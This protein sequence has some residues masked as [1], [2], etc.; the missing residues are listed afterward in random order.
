MKRQ[1]FIA[2]AWHG[3]SDARQWGYPS[4]HDS[5]TQN[6]TTYEHLAPQHTA[7]GLISMAT[8]SD[9]YEFLTL[10]AICFE[11]ATQCSHPAVT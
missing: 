3:I 7:S 9:E 2:M 4:Y 8:S 10:S 1:S 6:A 5:T 11:G